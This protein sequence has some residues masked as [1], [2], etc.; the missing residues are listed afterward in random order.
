[1]TNL[2]TATQTAGN[3]SQFTVNGGPVQT[4]N[5][6]SISDAISGVT[7]NLLSVGASTATISVDNEAVVEDISE[8]VTE[9][10]NSIT[11]IR[12]L[13][14][15]EGAARNDGSLRII[16]SF[17]RSSIF[18]GVPGVSQLF[19]SLLDVGIST[20]DSFDASAAFQI[21]LDEE[22]FLAALEDD[23][24]GASQLFT[25][26]AETGILDKIFLYLD[27][28]TSSTG[29]L[30]ERVRANGLI[31]DQIESQNS[32]IDQL[33]RRVA[34]FEARLRRQFIQL[35]QLTA[36][37]QQQGASLAGIGVGF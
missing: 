9:F 19:T 37:F 13:V 24:T 2:T 12:D 3:N 1:V 20:G 18:E 11:Q 36:G 31:D 4:R 34:T 17:L 16:E 14:A 6:N 21:E 15:P 29:F 23:R 32:R 8:L 5:S 26:E 7:L 30:N 27:E 28:A 33:E 22:A 10:N 35:E 25:N